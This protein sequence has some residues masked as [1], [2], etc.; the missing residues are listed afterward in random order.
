[1]PGQFNEIT[2][3]AGQV[4]AAAGAT[5]GIISRWKLVPGRTKPDG[6]PELQ[7][8]AQFRWKNDVTMSML[9]RGVLKGRVQVTFQS[10]LGLEAIDIVHWDQW[11]MDGGVLY[12]DNVMY[13]DSKVLKKRTVAR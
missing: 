4:L 2:G 9:A 1:M 7:F 13:F 11:R 6:T 5:V 3:D 10:K 8:K 12:L